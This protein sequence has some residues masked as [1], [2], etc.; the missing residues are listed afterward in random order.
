MKRIIHGAIVGLAFLAGAALADS[1]RLS[2]VAWSSARDG[3]TSAFP[4][5]DGQF[6]MLLPGNTLHVRKTQ[7]PVVQSEYRATYEFVLPPEVMQPGV[8]IYNGILEVP[9]ISETFAIGSDDLTLRGYVADN[10]ITLDDFKAP[11]I[12]SVYTLY[13]GSAPGFRFINIPY[14][15]QTFPGNGNARIGLVAAVSNWGTQFQWRSGATLQINYRPPI[16][17]VPTLTISAP[18]DAADIAAG[19]SVTLQGDA[20]DAE[21]SYM[22]ILWNS[23][24]S[25]HLGYGTSLTVN[26]PAG[27]HLI[28]ATV[29]DSDGNT[30]AKTRSITVH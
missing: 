24:V 21:T 15:L 22:S 30:V 23:N 2:P 13:A 26:L 4:I 5:V 3:G 27:I 18:A 1:V 14:H 29:V 6:E 9:V 12:A 28:T 10:T 25:G 11:H 8:T 19:S 7:G 16:G 17:S 20:S